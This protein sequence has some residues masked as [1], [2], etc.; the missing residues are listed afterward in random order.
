MAE[1]S[2][3]TR[4]F[5]AG[6]VDEQ[7]LLQRLKFNINKC[8][9]CGICE[10]LCPVFT[11]LFALWDREVEKGERLG[12]E[13]FRPVVDLCYYCKLCLLT[14]G[15]GVDLPRLML[16]SKVFYVQRHGQ[17][18]QNRL[19]MNT[20]LVGQLNGLVPP[21]ANLALTNPISR[22]L[23]EAVIG[24]D[25]RRTFP[26][27]PSQPFPR[28]YRRHVARRNPPSAANGRKVALFSGCYTDHFDPEV[29]IAATLV[30]EHNG[31]EIVY[32]EQRCC[33]IPKL[34]DGSLEAARENFR[35]NLSRLAP[36]VRQGYEVVV[37]S[38][39]CSMTFKQ[40][41]LDYL[42]GEEAELVA[43]HVFDISQYLHRMHER[44]ELKTD[45]Q[46]LPLKVAY[47]VPCAAK[48]Q[49]VERAALE[50]LALIPELQVTL[51]DRGCCGFDGTFGFKKQF[52]DLSMQVGKPLFEGIR[53]SGATH[54]ATDCPLCEVQITDGT[55]TVTV[56]P[57]ELLCQAYG[58]HE[59]R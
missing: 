6:L 33:G 16:E 54:T 8:Y 41:Y 29:G 7:D 36:L 25:R 13:D 45:F 40:E 26:K 30:L 55:H 12:M 14:C 24:V 34:A 17:T 43:R 18:F 42:G 38:T 57:I 51:I 47:H 53:Q 46:P 59:A 3:E 49:R 10:P 2:S 27:V 44:G 58:Y 11:P 20:D 4:P 19:L 22:R 31:V 37:I 48:A 52:F 5:I 35:Y 32:P 56:H 21:L 39:P 1:K 15:I 23:M 50:L 9:Y 28:W